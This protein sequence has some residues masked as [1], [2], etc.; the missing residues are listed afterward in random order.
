[1]RAERAQRLGD[2]DLHAVDGHPVLALERLGDVLVGHRSEGLALPARLQAEDERERRKACRELF[3]VGVRP[4]LLHLARLALLREVLQ[5]PRRRLD[6]K[7]ARKEEV[8]RVAV[9]DVL[10]LT[11]AAET[12]DLAPQD[13]AH[14]QD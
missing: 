6:R 9:R 7:P 4:V 3:G 2:V 13:D 1:M 8:L 14:G 5:L 11:G 12:A 10:H